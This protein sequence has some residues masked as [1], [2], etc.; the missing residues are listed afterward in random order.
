MRISSIYSY[1]AETGIFQENEVNTMAADA[2]AP[3]TMSSAAMV[4]TM[5]NNQVRAFHGEGFQPPISVLTSDGKYKYT[6]MY[7]HKCPANQGLTIICQGSPWDFPIAVGSHLCLSG[8]LCCVLGVWGMSSLN[9]DIGVWR[10]HSWW[11][12]ALDMCWPPRLLH[13]PLAQP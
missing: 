6:F 5:W 11:P 7:P 10:W 9:I 2:L 4:L 13:S 8:G 3:I 12:G 1:D